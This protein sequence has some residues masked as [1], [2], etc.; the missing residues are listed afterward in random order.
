MTF[1]DVDRSTT[2]SEVIL[3][4]VV[5]VNDGLQKRAVEILE[6]TV[7]YVSTA[8]PSFRWSR[9]YVSTDGRTVV[10][11]ALWDNQDDFQKLFSDGEFLA[12]YNQLSETGRWEYHLY[13]VAVSV[14][15]ATG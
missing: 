7:R 6:E 14:Y 13:K 15:G 11:Q 10:N 5:E 1:S 12:L 3:I 9:L 8:Y 2:G 4:N